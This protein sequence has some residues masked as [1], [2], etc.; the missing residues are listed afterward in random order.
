MSGGRDLTHPCAGCE[1]LYNPYAKNNNNYQW[2][3]CMYLEKTGHR[4]PCKGGVECTVK[5]LKPQKRSRP[6][7]NE[8][9][10]R[11]KTSTN[12]VTQTFSKINKEN[13]NG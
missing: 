11:Q 2:Q 6:R 5:K 1:Y 7:C 3:M 12:S 13:K 4:R 8:N 9:G 10:N